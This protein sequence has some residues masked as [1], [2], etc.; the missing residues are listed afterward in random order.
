[1]VLGH[2]NRP[3]LLEWQLILESVVEGL[4]T[5]PEDTFYRR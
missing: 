2:E 5:L 1:M 4:V 3:S